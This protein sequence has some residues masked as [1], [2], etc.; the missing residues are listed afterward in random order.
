MPAV[1]RSS[2]ERR[3]CRTYIFVEL[4]C[5]S[6]S[7]ITDPAWEE[8]QRGWARASET[9]VDR[10]PREIR[11]LEGTHRFCHFL[12]SKLMCNGHL[13]NGNLKKLTSVSLG[14]GFSKPDVNCKQF[15]SFLA[16]LF[17]RASPS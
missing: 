9:T 7:G 10:G 6:G 11:D 8:G 3:L 5:E 2:I 13:L 17:S 1:A 4:P 12:L 15:G 16:G 14:Q